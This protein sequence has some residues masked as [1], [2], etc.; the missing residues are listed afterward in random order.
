MMLLKAEGQHI[1]K[2]VHRQYL[3]CGPLAFSVL[4]RCF[5]EAR[6]VCY[7]EWAMGKDT[8]QHLAERY[9]WMKHQDPLREAFFRNLFAAHNVSSVLDCACGTGWDLVL[10]HSL[11]CEVYGSDLSEAML[12]QAEKRL[13]ESDLGVPLRQADFRYLADHVDARFDAVVCLSNS[14][15]ELLDD[16]DVLQALRSMATVLRDGG[17]LVLDQGQTDASMRNPPRF[18]PIVNERDFSRL[19]VMDYAR[20]VMQVHI[21][22]FVHTEELRDFRH[23][24]VRIRIR[25]RDDWQ[26]L[27][28]QAGLAVVEFYGDWE[29]SPYNKEQSKRL[30]AVAKKQEE[31]GAV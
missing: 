6:R 17:I 16:A 20:D 11:G 4:L 15:N 23:D 22:D 3:P 1:T 29:G 10:F 12:A 25:L 18:A 28:G 30:I 5:A 7:N 31:K 13:S 2:Q 9:D 14:I 21:F 8:Y 19:F 24:A 26:R 27:L